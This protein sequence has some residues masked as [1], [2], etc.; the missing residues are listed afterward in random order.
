M[1]EVYRARDPKLGRDVAVKV[2]PAEV[3]H[4]PDRLQRFEREANA[5]AAL[6]H[7]NVATL[8]GMELAV[9]ASPNGT[10]IPFLG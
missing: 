5:L 7:A 1:D 10:D 2:L 6:N 8:H 3:A 4:D 9:G